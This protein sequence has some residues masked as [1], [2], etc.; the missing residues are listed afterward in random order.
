MKRMRFLLGCVA[1]VLAFLAAGCSDSDS[2]GG[3]GVNYDVPGGAETMEIQGGVTIRNKVVNLGSSSDVYYEYLTFTSG[4]AGT[5]A[6]YKDSDGNKEKVETIFIDGTEIALP[7]KFE[8]ESPTGKITAGG[9][10]AYMFNARKGGKDV[11]VTASEILSTASEN[12]STLFNEWES[13]ADGK[14]TFGNDGYVITDKGGFRYTNTDGWILI[15]DSVP[16]YWAKKAGD[17]A[18]YYMAYETERENVEA[19]G[20]SLSS[21]EKYLVS[22]RFIVIR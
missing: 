5:Y 16:L 3:S 6:V 17:F 21:N 2:G 14:Y 12:K 7:E 8:Y 11:F 22:D 13:T 10:T 9:N 18:L 19:E 4:N 1:C 20:K 15:T